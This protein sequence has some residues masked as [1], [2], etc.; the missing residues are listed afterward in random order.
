[1][2]AASSYVDNITQQAKK[3][4]EE[5]IEKLEN[6]TAHR[7]ARETEVEEQTFVLHSI[8]WNLEDTNDFIIF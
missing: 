4:S 1:M 8:H 3:L 7:A 2:K 5:D 6:V